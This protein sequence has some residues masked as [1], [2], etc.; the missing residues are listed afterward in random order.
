[1]SDSR[2]GGVPR[3]ELKS[4]A[5]RHD[6][7]VGGG[8][9]KRKDSPKINETLKSLKTVAGRKIVVEKQKRY[10]K[11]RSRGTM[12][13]LGKKKRVLSRR[14]KKSVSRKQTR[15]RKEGFNRREPSMERG[16]GKS[17]GKIGPTGGDN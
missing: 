8:E 6:R 4:N 2:L 17:E 9:M 1:M 13:Q 15:T 5:T 12:F 3:K 7:N 16:A 11:R 10:E 14:G